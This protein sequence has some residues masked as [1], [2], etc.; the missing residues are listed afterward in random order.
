MDHVYI[1]VMEEKICDGPLER[2]SMDPSVAIR[3][4][5]T[6]LFSHAAKPCKNYK[7][8]LY[9]TVLALERVQYFDA[10]GFILALV[11]ALRVAAIVRIIQ[12]I[13]WANI[14]IN[15]R[16]LNGRVRVVIPTI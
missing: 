10:Q 8:T 11:V 6:E 9:D 2:I 1:R 13:S 4:V 12:V 16:L 5:F 3:Q 7:V 15:V 14:L